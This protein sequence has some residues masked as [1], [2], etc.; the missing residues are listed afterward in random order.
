MKG[1]PEQ[2]VIVDEYLNELLSQDERLQEAH[3]RLAATSLADFVESMHE[4]TKPDD[5]GAA[6]VDMR[7]TEDHDSAT[8]VAMIYPWENGH[9]PAMEMRARLIQDALD[10]P[11][12]FLLFPVDSGSM[13]LSDYDLNTWVR[14]RGDFEPV[15]KRMVA[16][17]EILG[18]D[19]LHIVGAS[20]GATIGAAALRFS[21]FRD[22]IDVRTACFS[23]PANTFLCS[24]SEKKAAF[25]KG[26]LAPMTK[27]KNDSAIPALSEAE[28]TRGG[29][30][31][32]RQLVSLLPLLRQ[33]DLGKAAH[34]GF[35]KPNFQWD[36]RDGLYSSPDTKALVVRAADSLIYT[37]E[38]EENVRTALENQGNFS[39]LTVA[40]Y[41]HE[42]NDNIVVNAILAK[43]AMGSYGLRPANG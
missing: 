28:F 12:R 43:L 33:S 17:A 23:E 21:G 38:G 31:R 42:M 20:M 41:G 8:A 30:D 15:G 14:Q 22:D 9:R 36:L 3:G 7:P 4:V 25:T 16:T 1:L 37:E 11:T 18:V 29:V 13:S 34:E 5:H 35:T 27:A 39:H 40:G 24:K 19:R 26:G 2:P 10:E 32:V 6:V